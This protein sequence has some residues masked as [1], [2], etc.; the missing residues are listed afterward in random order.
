[1]FSSDCCLLSFS[2]AQAGG[3]S[4]ACIAGAFIR[5]T[6]VVFILQIPISLVVEAIAAALTILFLTTLQVYLAQQ[7][8]LPDVLA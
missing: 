7:V 5:P 2:P 1:V 4:V 3:L 8:S 6:P